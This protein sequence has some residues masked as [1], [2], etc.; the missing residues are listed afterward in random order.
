M[1]N[2]W[3]LHGG[4]RSGSARKTVSH[5]RRATKIAA[6][7]T[8]NEASRTEREGKE[9]RTG[10]IQSEREGRLKEE[11]RDRVRG[12]EEEPSKGEGI[13]V[14][15]KI[16]GEMTQDYCVKLSIIYL[17]HTS[18]SDIARPRKDERKNKNIRTN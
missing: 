8:G 15:N 6:E 3:G 2:F 10:E 12:K 5:C 9:E 16:I 14:A 11:E 4:C 13:S 7:R 1:G 17:L 18:V